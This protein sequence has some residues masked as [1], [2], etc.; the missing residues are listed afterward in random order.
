MNAAPSVLLTSNR[1]GDIIPF[2]DEALK[3]EGLPF[4]EAMSVK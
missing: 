4:D 1:E 2:A 3:I